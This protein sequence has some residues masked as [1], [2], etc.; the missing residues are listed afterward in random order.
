[1]QTLQCGRTTKR[2]LE[3]DIRSLARERE[4]LVSECEN[5]RLELETSNRR[6]RDKEEEMVKLKEIVEKEV[7]S[8]H[9][10]VDKLHR[11]CVEP[12]TT[13]NFLKDLQLNLEGLHQKSSDAVE[14]ARDDLMRIIDSKHRPIRSVV[15]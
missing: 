3:G 8:L 9:S 1:M 15:D 10:L 11:A 13:S 7:N 5:A 2:K 14:H 12:P 4:G 6:L